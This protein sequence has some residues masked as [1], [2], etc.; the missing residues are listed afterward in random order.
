MFL[1]NLN[2]KNKRNI[3]KIYINWCTYKNICQS[4]KNHFI[5]FMNYFKD[6]K[7]NPDFE[8]WFMKYANNNQSIIRGCSLNLVRNNHRF[9]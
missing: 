1:K 8:S 2:R 9:Y 6:L 3:K 4:D 7:N 5:A